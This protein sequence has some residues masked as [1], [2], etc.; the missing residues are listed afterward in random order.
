LRAAAEFQA[1]FA[2][3]KR[4]SGQHFRLHARILADAV[5][6]RLG[7]AVSKKVAASAVVRNRVRRQIKEAFRLHAPRLP[8]GDYVFVAKPDAA[9]A[10]NRALRAELLSLLDRARTLKAL[11]ATGTMPP[12]VAASDRNRS[13]P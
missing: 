12:G 10:E 2:E 4:I 5:A 13:E 3:G 6:P 7:V 9:R 1:A 8:A 11:A